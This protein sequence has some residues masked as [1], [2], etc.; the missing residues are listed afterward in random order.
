M[1]GDLIITQIRD[2]SVTDGNA[3]NVGAEV[4]ERTSSVTSRGAIHDPVLVPHL[5][6]HL[7]L[8]L[9]FLEPIA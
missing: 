5:G 9:K 2:A 7:R 8:K 3:L 4:F 6:W 1:K